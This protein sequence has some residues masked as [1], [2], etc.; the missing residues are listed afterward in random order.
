MDTDEYTEMQLKTRNEWTC[1][2]CTLDN[3]PIAEKCQICEWPRPKNARSVTKHNGHSHPSEDPIQIIGE[4]WTCN[5]CKVP[6]DSK[7]AL[8]KICGTSKHYVP[9]EII[10]CAPTSD[11]SLAV[12]GTSKNP[13]VIGTSQVELTT[14]TCECGYNNNPPFVVNC[15]QCGDPR[16]H[17][18]WNCSHCG[19][20]NSPFEANCFDCG[21][22][23]KRPSSVSAETRELQ[24]K[25]PESSNKVYVTKKTKSTWLCKQCKVEN[26]ADTNKCLSCNEFCRKISINGHTNGS[27]VKEFWT[28]SKCTFINKFPA[29]ICDMCQT[30]RIA[31]LPNV[32]DSSKRPRNKPSTSQPS[33]PSDVSKKDKPT[34]NLQR[35]PLHKPA[36]PSFSKIP[37]TSES[38]LKSTEWECPLCT[39]HNKLESPKCEMCSGERPKNI[40]KLLF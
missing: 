29:E 14:W 27:E 38:K 19:S 37:S 23:R 8:C 31:E 3:P 11:T 26:S 33:Q 35:K 15:D 24:T 4:T 30:K 21:A 32:E 6:N 2:K 22:P 12:A 9:K 5:H 17:P 40:G 18:P 34:R 1:S 36:A 20:R 10:P 25:F 16:Q 7:D 39:F 28:C 13:I